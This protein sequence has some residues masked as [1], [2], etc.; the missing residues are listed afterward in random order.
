MHRRGARLGTPLGAAFDEVA[1]HRGQEQALQHGVQASPERDG[2]S[3]LVRQRVSEDL[4]QKVHR[5]HR[6]VPHAGGGGPG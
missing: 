5:E 2:L 4:V 1:P 3:S 6:L